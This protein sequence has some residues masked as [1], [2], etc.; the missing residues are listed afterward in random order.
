[1]RCREPTRLS[2]DRTGRFPKGGEG[3]TGASWLLADSARG[4]G[5]GPLL[6]PRLPPE[7][8]THGRSA[9]LVGLPSAR[10][11]KVSNEGRWMLVGVARLGWQEKQVSIPSSLH[12]E[13]RKTTT[14]PRSL[15]SSSSA[16]LFVKSLA[17]PTHSGSPGQSSRPPAHCC[18]FEMGLSRLCRVRSVR[19]RFFQHMRTH[20]YATPRDREIT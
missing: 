9:W 7:P 1:M 15:P 18:F 17:Q 20:F 16:A 12:G 6:F 4:R 3:V 10:T 14:L 8:P 13:R 19:A 5:R 11:T 2:P